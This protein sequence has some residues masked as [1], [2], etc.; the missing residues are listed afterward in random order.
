MY[1]SF[2][3]SFQPW[4]DGPSPTFNGRNIFSVDGMLK[5]VSVTEFPFHTNHVE[6]VVVVVTIYLSQARTAILYKCV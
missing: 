4:V 1:L 3:V 5:K 6:V 2:E